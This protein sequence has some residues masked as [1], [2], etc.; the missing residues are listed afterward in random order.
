L[1]RNEKIIKIKQNA[2]SDIIDNISK[3]L[4]SPHYA[5][6][7]QKYENKQQIKKFIYQI[8]D[9]SEVTRKNLLTGP[10]INKVIEETK[11]GLVKTL[12]K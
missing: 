8:F 2:I 3:D 1:K 9:G 5:L 11:N 12:F 4:Y 7:L 10:E 6:K